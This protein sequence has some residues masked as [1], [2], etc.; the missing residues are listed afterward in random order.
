MHVVTR[1]ANISASMQGL[2][3]I[4]RVGGIFIFRSMIFVVILYV[5]STELRGPTVPSILKA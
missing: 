3:T 5:F 4:D 1:R 2:H